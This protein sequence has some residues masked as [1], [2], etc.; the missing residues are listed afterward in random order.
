MEFPNKA[1]EYMENTTLV[2]RIIRY[3]I[4][5]KDIMSTVWLK[6]WIRRQVTTAKEDPNIKEILQIALKT[7][8]DRSD[9]DRVVV[10]LLRYVNTNFAYKNSIRT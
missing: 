5:R 8:G 3:L 6:P 9:Y 1:F 2:T 10:D 4:N 7:V